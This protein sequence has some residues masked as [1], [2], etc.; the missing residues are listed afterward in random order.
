MTFNSSSKSKFREKKVF[1]GSVYGQIESGT[2]RRNAQYA[3]KVKKWKKTH[4]L[5]SKVVMNDHDPPLESIW[6]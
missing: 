5:R 1:W 2:S 6:G 3:Q 4:I